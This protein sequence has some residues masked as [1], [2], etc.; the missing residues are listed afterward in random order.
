MR[1]NGYLSTALFQWPYSEVVITPDFLSDIRSSTLRT[2]TIRKHAVTTI[3]E[4]GVAYECAHCGYTIHNEICHIKSV[5]SFD[6]SSTL[7][8]I[9]DIKNLVYLCPTHHWEFDNG[10]LKFNASGGLV[11]GSPHKS[12]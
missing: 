6:N 1:L 8:E 10:Y 5:S 2:A 11:S 9:N 4:N 3:E 12:V 7:A